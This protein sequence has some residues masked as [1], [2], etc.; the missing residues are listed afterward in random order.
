[1]VKEERGKQRRGAD[2]PIFRLPAAICVLMPNTDR[3]GGG[4]SRKISNMADRRKLKEVATELEVPEGM[5]VIIRTAGANRTKQEIKRDFEYLMRQWDAVRELTLRS[6]APTVVYEEG[7]LV[8]RAIRDLYSKDVSEVLVEGEQGFTDAHEF[9]QMLMPSHADAVKTVSRSGAASISTTGVEGPRS[10]SMFKPD[11][12]ICAR[13]VTSSSTR[14]KALVA[15]D[16]NLGQ[17]DARTP[18]RRHRAQDQSRGGGGSFAPA[19]PARPCRPHRH[20]LHRYGGEPQQSRRRK[21]GSRI[22]CAFDRA[23]HSA[24]PQSAPFGLLEMSRQRLRAGMIEGATSALPPLRRPRRHPL[25]RLD[26]AAACCAPSKS[27]V[28][29]RNRLP[30]RCAC[31]PENRALHPQP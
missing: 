20:R 30:S 18:H 16:V 22:V 27:F 10:T 28:S 8:K 31:P 21:N 17:G 6:S 5:G 15:V 3:G 24:R 23:P 25:G 13:A 1:V 29:A 11:R 4:I 7:N 2:G 14:P 19:A 26:G 9:M 12:A